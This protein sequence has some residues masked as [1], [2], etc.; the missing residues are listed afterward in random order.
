MVISQKR[1]DCLE[2]KNETKN[3]LRLQSQEEDGNK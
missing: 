1:A 3:N 2:K